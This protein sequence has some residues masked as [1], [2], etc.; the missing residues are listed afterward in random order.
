MTSSKHWLLPDGVE[1]ILPAEAHKLETLRRELLDLYQTWGYE[2]VITPLIE[3][4]D[5]LLVGTSQDLDL[6]TFKITDQISGRLMGIRADITPQAAR[7]DSSCLQRKSAVR[8]CYADHVLH[9][10]PAGIMTSRVPLRIGAELFGHAGVDCDIELISLMLETLSMAGITECQVVLGHVGI[11]RSLLTEAQLGADTESQLFAAVQRKAFDE[12]DQVIAEFVRDEALRESLR[13][14]TRLSGDEQVLEEAKSVFC[15]T[16]SVQSE[17]AELVAIGEGV[18][19]CNPQVQLGFDLCEL[20]GYAYHTGIVFA[21]YT[22]N[23]GRAVA[24]GGRYDDIGEV[25]GRARPASGFDSD[26]K[27]LMKLSNRKFMRTPGIQAPA[28]HSS[29]LMAA[30]KS[31]REQGETVIQQLTGEVPV[32][33]DCKSMQCDRKLVPQNG[34]WVVVVI[35]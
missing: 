6:H 22:S 2:L 30:I 14:L 15:G 1:E 7:I 29:G 35:D 31:L 18:K 10:K 25:F 5:S 20:R 12:S 23:Y 27:T 33:R 21:A 3:F 17:L 13:H 9:T 4:L 32:G 34:E 16:E 26:L 19:K 24:Q 8:L 28:G 11:F